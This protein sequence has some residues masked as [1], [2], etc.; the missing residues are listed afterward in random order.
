VEAVAAQGLFVGVGA[1]QKPEHALL[2]AGRGDRVC[3]A[4]RG[5]IGDGGDSTH[6][7]VR[8]YIYCSWKIFMVLQN[9]VDVF[10]GYSV[11]FA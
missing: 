8:A 6:A 11:G 9:K 2:G 1:D 7:W 10:S 3:G 5:T 4:K